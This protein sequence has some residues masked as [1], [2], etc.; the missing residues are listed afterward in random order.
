MRLIVTLF[1]QLVNHAPTYDISN[2]KRTTDSIYLIYFVT[3]GNIAMIKTSFFE[4]ITELKQGLCD[5]IYAVRYCI[6]ST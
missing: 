6:S 4:P 2:E 3:C 5:M 1:S